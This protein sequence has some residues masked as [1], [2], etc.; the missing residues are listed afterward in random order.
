MLEF[1]LAGASDWV[2]TSSTHSTNWHI[3]D[4]RVQ[5]SAIN[6][7]IQLMEAY[8][9]HVLSG[10]S[11]LIQLKTLLVPPLGSLIPSSSTSV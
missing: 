9:A 6:I 5:A 4:V 3:S 11:L 1:E 8:S 7:N 10:K 2:S